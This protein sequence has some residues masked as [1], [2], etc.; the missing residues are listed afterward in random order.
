MLL[1]IASVNDVDIFLSW[2]REDISNEKTQKAI[3]A[4]NKR[5]RIGIPFLC[6]PAYFLDRL[7]GSIGSKSRTLSLSNC[8]VP[9]AY[10]LKFF[11][12]K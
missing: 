2:N 4:I 11:P 12:S 5:K 7:V 1:A 10:R 8:P 6:T 9:R 3:E